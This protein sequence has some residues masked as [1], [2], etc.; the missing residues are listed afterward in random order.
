VRQLRSPTNFDD[1]GGP[2]EFSAVF[3]SRKSRLRTFDTIS[4]SVECQGVGLD[5]QVPLYVRTCPTTCF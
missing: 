2:I 1:A 3:G 5:T 4:S